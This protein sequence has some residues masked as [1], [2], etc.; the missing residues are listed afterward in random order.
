[1]VM[2]RRPSTDHASRRAR[3]A[4]PSSRQRLR[5]ADWVSAALD[6]I[7]AGGV[8]NVSIERLAR[9]L[10]TT[11]GS[12][13]WHF[14]DRPALIA[15]ALDEWELRQ[16][17]R[18]IERL[19]AIPEPAERLRALLDSAFDASAGV[20][21]DANLLADADDPTV[22]SALQRSTRKR[23]AFVAQL[24]RELDV[25]G[26]DDRALLAFSAYLGLAQ[27][28]RIAPELAPQG[29][30]AR[31]YSDFATAWLLGDGRAT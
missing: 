11:K 24:F 15:A 26:S 27:L 22:G 28:R 29:T 5:P 2:A 16:T 18:I 21:L 25:T 10:G 12:F 19:A 4:A 8:R 20:L 14:A 6:A 31:G 1:M 3:T 13:Y 23:L 17:D 9:D 7:A 30:A